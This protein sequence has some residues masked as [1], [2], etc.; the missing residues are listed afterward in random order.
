PGLGAGEAV[1]WLDA[2]DGVLALAR[3]GFVCTTNTR[4]TEVELPVPGRVLLSSATPEFTG[5]TVRLPADS[6]TWWAI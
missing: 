3:D 5:G 6:S 1:T 2:P 4:G